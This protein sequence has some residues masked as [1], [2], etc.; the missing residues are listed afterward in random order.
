[1]SHSYCLYYRQWKYEDLWSKNIFLILACDDTILKKGDFRFYL[2]R[3]SKHKVFDQPSVDNGGLNMGRSVAVDFNCWLF[4]FQQHFNSTLT[5]LP[6]HLICIA[7][8][9]KGK[10]KKKNGI[11]ASVCI[12]Q[13]IPCLPYTG[14]FLVALSRWKRKKYQF[15]WHFT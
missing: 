6:R 14:F 11:S 15:L 9:K 2:S 4:A 5:P 3:L 13:E 8:T 7:M 1:M 10:K 12:C